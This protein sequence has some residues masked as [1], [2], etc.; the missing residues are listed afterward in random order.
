MNYRTI[1][2]KKIKQIAENLN[3]TQDIISMI[4]TKG[5]TLGF[6]GYGQSS[7]L[8]SKDILI[9]PEFENI[10]DELFLEIGKGGISFGI[11]SK[12]FWNNW[13][14]E[15]KKRMGKKESGGNNDK[16]WNGV[17][18]VAE[19]SGNL[20][21]SGFGKVAFE[22]RFEDFYQELRFKMFQGVSYLKY[23]IIF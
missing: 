10:D 8:S 14:E 5:S 2:L 12:L 21:R 9:Y 17:V 15:S 23:L 3:K 13:I 1:Y 19:G 18:L 6:G 22:R 4:T 7:P 20:E 16:W 11:Y